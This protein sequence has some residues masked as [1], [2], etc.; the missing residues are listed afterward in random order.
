MSG[1]KK[2]YDPE[3][4]ALPRLYIGEIIMDDS[5]R[6][7]IF[8]YL[9]EGDD[10][11]RIDFVCDTQHLAD[12]LL[13]AGVEGDSL[14]SIISDSLLE[15]KEDVFCVDAESLFG[16]PVEVTGM[17]FIVYAPMQKDENGEYTLVD[18]SCYFIDNIQTEEDFILNGLRCAS[19]K[20]LSNEER[21]EEAI[22]TLIVSYKQY[23]R[24]IEDGASEWQARN[25]TT[26][27]NETLFE[28]A[29]LYYS[30]RKK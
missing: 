28:L 13:H 11:R 30:I 5:T 18:H 4:I 27:S 26:L 17:V 10:L 12:M 24:L 7:T 25:D 16:R 20:E 8:G 9:P 15:E 2:G 6:V 29:E 19:P 1:L 3:M 14:I 22:V 23:K 21:L